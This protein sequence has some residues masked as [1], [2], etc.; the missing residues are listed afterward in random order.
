[1]CCYINAYICLVFETLN[2][3]QNQTINFINVQ[4]QT[5]VCNFVKNVLNFFERKKVKTTI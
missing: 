1:M 2:S 3:F 5:F 4:A